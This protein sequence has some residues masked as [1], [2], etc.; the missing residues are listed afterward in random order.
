MKD[1][2]K[3]SDTELIEMVKTDRDT[4]RQERFKDKFSRK[5]SIIRTAKTGIA[6]ALTELNVRRRNQETK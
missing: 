1:I 2:Q 3:K 6:R 5:A 4:V